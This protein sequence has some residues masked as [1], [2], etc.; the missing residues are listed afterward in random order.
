MWDYL[1]IIGILVTV[2]LLAVLGYYY[3]QA[4]IQR[5]QWGRLT[6]AVAVVVSLAISALITPP[7]PVSVAIFFIPVFTAV[8]PLSYLLI[9][10]EGT[11]QRRDRWNVFRNANTKGENRWYENSTVLWVGGAVVL[12]VVQKLSQYIVL[13]WLVQRFNIG[14][15]T[16]NIGGSIVVFLSVICGLAPIYLFWAYVSYR[17]T[18]RESQTY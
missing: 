8:L 12:G 10:R 11:Q 7:D 4:R 15:L 9:Y 1:E 14:F 18:T 16:G 3:I 5:E 13:P 17:E 2:S 6:L